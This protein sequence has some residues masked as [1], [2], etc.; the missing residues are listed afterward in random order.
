M[1]PGTSV[2]GHNV[3]YGYNPIRS[4]QGFYGRP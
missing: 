4:K 1:I 3:G 2:T